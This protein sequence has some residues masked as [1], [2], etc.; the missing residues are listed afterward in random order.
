MYIHTTVVLTSENVHVLVLTIEC[1]HC[2]LGKSKVTSLNKTCGALEVNHEPTP[3]GI[4]FQL[5]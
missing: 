5:H 2:C 1:H 4:V 3:V